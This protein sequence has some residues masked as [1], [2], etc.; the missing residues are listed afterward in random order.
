MYRNKIE[1]QHVEMKFKFNDSRQDQ[2]VQF[3]CLFHY[4]CYY[5]VR[6]GYLYRNSHIQYNANSNPH[7]LVRN[8]FFAKY[9]TRKYNTFTDFFY[10][11]IRNN[12]ER[13]LNNF[14]FIW[15]IGYDLLFDNAIYVDLPLQLHMQSS[16]THNVLT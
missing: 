7:Q 14:D 15:I 4:W 12:T 6:R 16:K 1:I 8:L 3:F 10:W 2:I 9:P 11:L 13:I 5:L